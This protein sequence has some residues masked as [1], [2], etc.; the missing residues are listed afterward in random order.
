MERRSLG[1]KQSM[2]GGSALWSRTFPDVDARLE[3]IEAAIDNLPVAVALLHLDGRPILFNRAFRDLYH[4]GDNV[5]E[6]QTFS[7]MLKDGLF[8]NFREDPRKHFK[9]MLAAIQEGHS[10]SAEIEMGGRVIAIHDA[11]LDGRY[12]LSTQ[13][14]IT[15]R[16]AAERRIAYLALH[17]P[18]T[19]LPNRAAFTNELA[20]IMEEAKARS[21]EFAVLAVDLDH[22][23]DVNDV[24]GH[25]S[26]DALLREVAT[27]FRQAVGSGFL[28]R[29]GGDE[30]TFICRGGSQ[31]ETAAALADRIFAHASG[32]MVVNDRPLVVG[33][34]MGIAVYPT[35]GEDVKAL[36]NNADAALYRSKAEG[37]GTVR[38]YKPEMDE[39]IH[40]Q[41]LLQQDLRAA[42]AR[43]ELRLHYQ[44][45]ATVAGKVVGFEALIRWELPRL[46]TVMPG[47]FIPLAEKSGLIID[48]G[49]WILR[50]ACREAA[51]WPEPLQIAINLSPVQFRHGDLAAL[52][53][54]VLLDT[55]L[56]PNRL[57]LEITETALIDDFAR[58]LSTLRRIK[59]L[60]VRIAMDDFG[61]GYSSLSYLQAFPFDKL[62]IDRTFIA[63]VGR[64]EHAEEIVRA[65]IGLGRGLKLPIVAEG[66]ETQEQLD[67]LA[68]ANCH[69]IQGYLIGK[70]R[71]ITSYAGICEGATPKKARAR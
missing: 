51:S 37:R 41:R 27:R 46:G 40:E 15:E 35:D 55:G 48:I 57:E 22:F 9:R 20:T 49:E 54:Q 30:F 50:E 67:F 11:P 29:L 28:A 59:S 16:V 23:K 31:P 38:F 18:L 7:G 60:G 71:P 2:V 52:V 10:Y 43:N 4:I 45:Q 13:Q 56:A 1:K 42:V 17:D 58:A 24:F 69:G 44:P 12:I 3:A 47:D 34:S 26:G 53:H 64:N 66:V 14:D 68:E 5:D 63:K 6:G 25:A 65:V 36:L 8:E 19:E 39:K 62:K 70:P 33:L 21:E 32:E 61:T